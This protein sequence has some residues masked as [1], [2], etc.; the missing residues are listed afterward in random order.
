MGKDSLKNDRFIADNTKLE[1]YFEMV[2][3]K[4]ELVDMSK[5]KDVEIVETKPE[6]LRSEIIE[7]DNTGNFLG[8][9]DKI[10]NIP[11]EYIVFPFFT[12]RK[13]GRRINLEYKF[14]DL[15]IKM[16][17]VLPSKVMEGQNIKQPSTFEKEVFEAIIS[18][19]QEVYEERKEYPR[20]V[21][22]TPQRFVTYFLGNKMN[23]K[24]YS[25]IEEALRNLKYT[26]YIFNIKNHKKA[27]NFVFDDRVFSLLNYQKGKMGKRI[28]YKIELD[29][30]II[31]KIKDKRYIK[32]KVE[33]I[34]EISNE[35]P[36]ALRIYEYISSERFEKDE[37]ENRL[38]TFCAIAPLKT[39]YIQRKKLKSGE[40]KE[41]VTSRLSHT[42]KRITKAFDVLVDLEYIKKYKI[43]QREE[44]SSWNFRYWFNNDKVGHISSYLPHTVKNK[45]YQK[46]IN[47]NFTKKE[48]IE[49]SQAQ[50][51][52]IS[53]E[54]K[55]AIKKAKNKNIYFSKS[56][57]KAA[58]K[59][60]MEMDPKVAI[61]VCELALE[62]L[63]SE[64]RT[65]LARYLNS[66]EKQIKINKE[67]VQVKKQSPIK[68]KNSEKIKMETEKEDSKIEKEN[69]QLELKF[70]KKMFLKI[71]EK[72]RENYKEKAFEIYKEELGNNKISLKSKEIFNKENV[73]WSYI[74]KAVELD[75]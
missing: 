47:Q 54:V 62:G 29:S 66:I 37:G 56:Y 53:E 75:E 16:E 13:R 69:I 14:K 60:L 1:K 43:I 24:Y 46:K 5:N 52:F 50:E 10:Y 11:L 45:K 68:N 20:Y 34:K 25:R 23:K 19:Y 28:I 63:K 26:D 38:E 35:D 70:F 49:H 21:Y 12:Y 42:L 64:I 32:F 48:K 17:S 57:D 58:E 18:M 30:N 74:K 40:V 65:S 8:T 9:H 15:G 41:Y 44:D 73:K 4:F 36:I 2:D 39:K 67:E 6:T 59:K 27:G 72:E 71:P 22:L 55:E 7:I 33:T 51:H 31:E 61:K 3:K